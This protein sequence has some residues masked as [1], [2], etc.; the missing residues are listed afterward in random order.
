MEPSID[1]HDPAVHPE[2]A[3]DH[4][5]GRVLTFTEQLERIGEVALVILVGALLWQIDVPAHVW[6]FVPLLFFV[7]RPVSV[8]LGLFDSAT[9]RRQRALIAWF[10]IRGIGSIYYLYY[11]LNHGVLNPAAEVLAETV[12]VVIACSVVAHGISVTPLMSGYE[13]R[14]RR[15]KAA[16]A[17]ADA[18]LRR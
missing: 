7:I 8:Y 16:A 5:T 13:R 10:G 3:P 14:R 15:D 1:S 9:R 18:A 17:G 11:A 6:W 12:L 2:Q 4:M